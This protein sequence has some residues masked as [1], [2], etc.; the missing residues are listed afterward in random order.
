MK[1]FSIKAKIALAVVACLAAIAATNLVLARYNYASDMSFAAEQ[2]VQAAGQGFVGI[3]QRETDKLSTA[4]DALAGDPT[5]TNLF[6]ARQREQLVAATL[7][8]FQELKAR[9]G[10]THWYFIE[11]SPSRTCF[12]RVHR[13]DLHGDV[14]NRA[15]LLA[16]IRTNDTAAGKELGETAFALRVVRPLTSRGTVLGYM[17]LGEEIDSFLARMKAETHD[18]LALVVEKRFLDA[19]AYAAVMERA[20]RR[21]NWGDDPEIVAIDST[22]PSAPIV[23]ASADVRNVPD[24]GR[25]LATVERGSSLFVRGV[26]PVIDAGGRRVGGLFVLHD[27]TAIRDRARSEQLRAVLLMAIAALFLLALLFVSF[28]R[29]VFRRLGA[30]TSAME[31]VSLRLAGGDYDVGDTIQPSAQDEIGRFESFLRSFLQTIGATLRELEKRHRKT[32]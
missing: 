12:L 19:S 23:G 31:N 22:D 5:F 11:P 20:N 16:S 7:P 26:A 2:A 24:G 21:N 15:T 1:T 9:H 3:E 28:E 4:L 6:A 8:I 17:E 32:G 14:V 27:V 29:L 18:D 13:P 10:V 30:M 25:N